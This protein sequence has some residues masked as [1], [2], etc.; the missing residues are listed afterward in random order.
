V[1]FPFY[2]DRGGDVADGFVT[3]LIFE[4]S[5]DSEGFSILPERAPELRTGRYSNVLGDAE[6]SLEDGNLLL[7]DRQIES[8]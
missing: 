5:C 2:G 4:L 6:G 1:E 3:G 8:F 7:D